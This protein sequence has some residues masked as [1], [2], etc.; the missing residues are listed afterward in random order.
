MKEYIDPELLARIGFGELLN[1]FEECALHR[2]DE[3]K[4]RQ[5]KMRM[6]PGKLNPIT[7]DNYHACRKE[8]RARVDRLNYQIRMLKG[9]SLPDFIEELSF[10]VDHLD[11]VR[12]RGMSDGVNTSADV[13]K[14]GRK[15]LRKA[16]Q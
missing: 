6:I 1:T 3:L 11:A 7:R 2:H 12:L 9:E 10:I 16:G 4:P 13:V 14:R 15:A 5:G 8:I